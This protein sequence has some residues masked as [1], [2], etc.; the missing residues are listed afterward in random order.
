ML[1]GSSP[2]RRDRDV[3]GSHLGLVYHVYGLL[4]QRLSGLMHPG[5]TAESW[6]HR[7]NM[8]HPAGQEKCAEVSVATGNVKVQGC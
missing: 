1:K 4:N 8:T 6:L 3:Q 5:Q 2:E 7:N